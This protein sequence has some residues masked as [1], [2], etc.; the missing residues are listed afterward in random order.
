MLP[1]GR[2]FHEKA[3]L[4]QAICRFF[5]L[6]S[7]ILPFADQRE[8][9]HSS[10]SRQGVLPRRHRYRSPPTN[11]RRHQPPTYSFGFYS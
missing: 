8:A 11:G 5:S 2:G 7:S 9:Q 10:T 3:S 4:C 1:Y 6:R